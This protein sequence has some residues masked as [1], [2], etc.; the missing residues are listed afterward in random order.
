MKG[1]VRAGFRCHGF[2]NAGAAVQHPAAGD[3]LWIY[4]FD[5]ANGLQRA[6]RRR[7]HYKNFT[8]CWK[9][10]GQSSDVDL[11]RDHDQITRTSE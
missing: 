2:R 8:F 1:V 3:Q 9:F 10:T 6:L 5:A 7:T 4:R 11:M